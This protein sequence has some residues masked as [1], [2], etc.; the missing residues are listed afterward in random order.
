MVFDRNFCEKRPIQE[1][2]RFDTIPECN[3]QTDGWTDGYA[4]AYTALAARCKNCYKVYLV[5]PIDNNVTGFAPFKG[6]FP[7]TIFHYDVDE[8]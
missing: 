2:P 1:F 7:V 8:N 4:V 3:R 5:S 6:H